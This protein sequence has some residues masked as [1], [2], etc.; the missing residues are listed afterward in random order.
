ME[1]VK[2]RLEAQKLA[3]SVVSA[4]NTIYSN[5]S[6]AKK[7]AGEESLWW[8]INCS[9]SS[10]T[11]ARD[12]S[13]KDPEYAT[14]TQRQHAVHLK[15]RRTVGYP[16]QLENPLELEALL[17]LWVWSL[18][19]DPTMETQDTYSHLT[20]SRATEIAT[21]RIVSTAEYVESI[22]VWLGDANPGLQGST[23]GLETEGGRPAD[24]FIHNQSKPGTHTYKY[25]LSGFGQASGFDY[26][27]LKT[28]L[29]NDLGPRH[30]ATAA[31]FF[32]WHNMESA[33]TQDSQPTTK[34]IRIF[35]ADT[36]CSLLSSCAHEIFGY[37]IK[38][39]L[40]SGYAQE[41]GDIVIEQDRRGFRLDN[42]FV[43]ELTKSFTES[44]LGSR[45]E[46]LLCILPSVIARLQLPSAK[47]CLEAASNTAKEHRKR[48]EWKDAELVLKWAWEICRNSEPQG[49]EE[50][51]EDY[52]SRAAIA[53]GELYRWAL[54]D[55]TAR[56][57][58]SNGISWLLGQKE[59]LSEACCEVID[60]Y[61]TIRRCFDN[62]DDTKDHLAAT[63][64]RLTRGTST[65]GRE[66][67]GDTL[68][69]AAKKGWTEVV[70]ALLESATEPDFKDLDSRTA[71][72]Y[73]AESGTV[74]VTKI[75]IRAGAFPDPRDNDG[76]TPM[77]FAIYGGHEVVVRLLLQNDRVDINSTNNDGRT[78]LHIALKKGHVAIAHLLVSS[79][80]C[81]LNGRN[82]HGYG[83]LSI[84]ARY[85]HKA[86]V[87]Q[88]LDTG[89]VDLGPPSSSWGPLRLA[90]SCG[91]AAVVRLLLE[92]GKFD[93]DSSPR[94]TA[95]NWA[96]SDAAEEGQEAT[97]Q[98][99]LE[100]GTVDLDDDTWP[101]RAVEKA[102]GNGH[103]GVVKLLLESGRLDLNG[104]TWSRAFKKGLI[105]AVGS[106][107]EGVVKLLLE[108]GKVSLDGDILPEV[109]QALRRAAETR[110]EGVL[111]LLLESGKADLGRDSLSAGT[112]KRAA[113]SGYKGV[114]ELLVKSGYVHV[115]VRETRGRTLL[116][117]AA[118]NGWESVV[119]LLLETGKL[120]P[121]AVDNYGQT[122]MQLATKYRRTHVVKLF[123]DHG[124]QI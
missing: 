72:S 102:A 16:W 38:A 68:I 40:D 3:A 15:F 87:K 63:L 117:I 95:P 35:S 39:I 53:L 83:P 47:S 45:T 62:E 8:E 50:L 104:D 81:D 49:G 59:F 91:H 93:M 121:D 57:F 41:L 29:S 115:D 79:N 17:G 28:R 42:S 43:A 4:I 92:S 58:G 124:Y 30:L 37:F 86:V 12:P 113:E 106:G 114:V 111:K 22:R 97:V 27:L 25:N 36:D 34:P 94:S 23:L 66:A 74:E 122:A 20:R 64:L 90:A 51:T 73:A 85:G 11:V 71:I 88:L 46:A 101:P 69:R 118:D 120:N 96:I 54:M 75:L 13:S 52:T 80:K 67:K 109:S 21:R 110:H 55:E 32:G 103:K 89:K 1:M 5:N 70:L 84:A 19:S 98:L 107:H 56:N 100:S 65:M 18:I 60:R 10:I 6:W 9:V 123:Q 112:L 7:R 26:A 44:R 99:L 24:V 76:F 61:D 48:K 119:K 82:G 77:M 31:R 108:S 78:P 14:P 105:K 116:H 2:V 33:Q